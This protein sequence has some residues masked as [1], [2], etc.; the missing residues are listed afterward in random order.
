MFQRLGTR[1]IPVYRLGRRKT[2]RDCVLAAFRV[3]DGIPFPPAVDNDHSLII[4]WTVL[5]S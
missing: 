3:Q 4:I 2:A 1:A 5:L